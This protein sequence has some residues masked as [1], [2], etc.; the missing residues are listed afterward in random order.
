MTRTCKKLGL[1]VGSNPLP[2]YLAAMAL[3]PAEVVLVYTSETQGPKNRLLEVFKSKGLNSR[4]A[5]ISDATDARV[6]REVCAALDYDHLHYSGGTKPMAAHARKAF[7]GGEANVSYLDERRALLRFEDGCD[8]KLSKLDLGLTIKVLLSLHGLTDKPPN[9]HASGDPSPTDTSALAQSVLEDSTVARRLY[10][11]FCSGEQK[12]VTRAKEHPLICSEHELKLTVSK[13]P[14]IDWNR[15]R[16]DAWKKFLTGGWL[17]HWTAEKIHSVLN[18]AVLPIHEGVECKRL[19]DGTGRTF[20]IDVA[21]LFRQR[22]YV[23][24]CTTDATL[25]Q[26][27]SKLFEVAMRSRQMGGDLARCALVCL[28]GRNDQVEALRSDIENL[29][30][31]PNPPRV[32]GLADLREWAGINTQPN[33]ESLRRWLEE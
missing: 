12:N 6:I 27:K 5:H 20:E 23:A 11:H 29:W 32:F 31:A 28:L 15:T 13:V 10:E 21:L 14:D 33:L 16:Y 4:E 30:D 2:N 18:E 3:K 8:E 26:C 25:G 24:S 9:H 17:E 7:M 1:L 19:Q 22:L